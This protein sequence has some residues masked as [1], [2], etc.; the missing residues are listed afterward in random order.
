[1][2]CF[3]SEGYASITNDNNVVTGN[4]IIKSMQT[5]IQGK[6]MDNREIVAILPTKFLL[7]D[8]VVT[9]M[10]LGMQ[11]EKLRV[12]TVVATVP[13]KNVTPIVK[14]LE[15]INVTVVDITVGPIGDYEFKN[16][17]NS[18]EVGA[19][20]NIGASKTNVA[21]FNKGIITGCEVIDMGGEAIDYDL[22]YVYK[23]NR[24]DALYLKESIALADKT[25][26]QPSESIILDNKNGE[27]IKINQFDASEIVMGRLEE[28]LNLA[29]K[30]INL[31]QGELQK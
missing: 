24:K 21:I 7:N 18:G 8:S 6:I 15:K 30:Q 23:I 28:I 5:A 2:E 26:A 27:K 29:K 22:G 10:P 9:D 19:V 14:I 12:K 25:N 16:V 11:A 17:K 31:L 4:D 1:M 3:L 20:I 13:K